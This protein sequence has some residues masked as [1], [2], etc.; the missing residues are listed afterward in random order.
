MVT[1]V[2]LSIWG[3]VFGKIASNIDYNCICIS[4]LEFVATKR[5]NLFIATLPKKLRHVQ[6]QS[7]LLAFWPNI[8]PQIESVTLVIVA[9]NFIDV[10][11]LM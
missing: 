11:P 3:Y 9:C 8:Y 10:A 5:I 4:F 1:E 7:I 6:L 2:A